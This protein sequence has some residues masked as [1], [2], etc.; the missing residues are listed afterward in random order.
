MGATLRRWSVGAALTLAGLALVALTAA[1]FVVPGLAEKQAGDALRA[2]G[3]A[4]AR[5]VVSR[6][7]LRGA[8]AE[9]RLTGGAGAL[10]TPDGPPHPGSGPGTA[11]IRVDYSPLGLLAGRVDRVTLA[12]LRLAVSIGPGGIEVGGRTATRTLSAGSAEIGIPVRE[13]A[14]ED[15]LLAFATPAGDTLITLAGRLA[16]PEP[17]RFEGRAGVRLGASGRTAVADIEAR[18]GPEGLRLGL[19][20]GMPVAPGDAAP[21]AT[22]E[23]H[24]ELAAGPEPAVSARGAVA[25]LPLPDGTRID[26]RFAYAARGSA[27]DLAVELEATAEVRVTL[28]AEVT[29]ARDA[30][31][32]LVATLQASA[33][34]LGRI[35]LPVPLAGRAELIL[36]ADGPL[37]DG[38]PALECQAIGRGLTLPG[39]FAAGEASLAG[40]LR[41]A[42]GGA[43]VEAR[44]P[45]SLVARVAPR[46]AGSPPATAASQPLS[47]VLQPAAD[48]PLR[49]A[50]TRAREGADL[51]F[52]GGVSVTAGDFALAGD[53][54][55]RARLH[56][57]GQAVDGSARLLL[58]DLT[59]S[60][61]SF[62]ARGVSGVLTASS[63]RPLVMPPGQLLAVAMLDVGLPLTDGLFA[64]EVARDGTLR[65]EQVALHWAGGTVRAGPAML[66]PGAGEH[67]LTLEAEGMDLGQV[68]AL[69]GV[70]GL[71][72]TGTLAGQI[73]LALSGQEVRFVKGR[74]ASVGEGYIRYD[75]AHPPAFLD[76]GAGEGMAL[77]RQALQDFH[78]SELSVTIDGVAGREMTVGLRLNGANPGFQDGRPV[79][80]NLNLSGALEAVL[81]DSL[82]S[83]RIPD[84]VRER[85]QEFGR[86]GP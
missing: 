19:L 54:A 52:D 24:A 11:Q 43:Q 9:L 74:L 6:L 85:I 31:P 81:R 75:P 38:L 22:A 78:Y 13:V 55:L 20:A 53:M 57:D 18:A 32:R 72:G 46:L 1:R 28:Q 61:P 59:L 63:L 45:W 2:L 27:H 23:V 56:R 29:V 30:S 21:A 7:G 16:Q 58:A 49:L 40:R 39:V 15:V 66:A 70:E 64:F 68:L 80:L 79:A 35:A 33:A 83:Y 14:F 84:A 60:G 69:A 71:E 25:G 50:V 73:P 67:A 37:A 86:E 51:R 4:E 10:R 62:S 17:G 48:H 8:E 44:S 41:F 34:D 26:G 76:P 47:L 5:V 36:R 3:F 42:D 82:R 65:I 77:L 12:G